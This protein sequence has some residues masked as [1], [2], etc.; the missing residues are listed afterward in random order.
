M[1]EAFQREAFDPNHPG[2]YI[3][4]TVFVVMSFSPEMDESYRAIQVGAAEHGLQAYRADD[5]IGSGII[6]SQI[7]KAIEE[8]EF[9]VVDLTHERPNVYYELGYA[10][11]VGNSSA[12][13]LLVAKSGSILHFDIGPMRVRF[14]SSPD[15]LVDIIRTG[16]GKMKESTRSP[17]AESRSVTSGGVYSLAF[18]TPVGGFGGGLI[19]LQKGFIHGGDESYLYLGRYRVETATKISGELT[20]RHYRGSKLSVLGYLSQARLKFLAH[21]AGGRFVGQA[22]VLEMS[23]TRIEI[24]GQRV[25]DAF[26]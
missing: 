6:L 5:G 8:A 9:I 4:D 12:D 14:Y 24:E 11:G 17:V 10:H 7:T 16:L 21:Q 3:P 15:E 25:A 18:K 20:V 23:D 19:L 13:I 22:K 2:D 26:V 1:D